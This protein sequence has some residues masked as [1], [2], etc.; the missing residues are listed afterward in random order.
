[1]DLVFQNLWNELEGMVSFLIDLAEILEAFGNT[2]ASADKL[3]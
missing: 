1:M 3:S 2:P